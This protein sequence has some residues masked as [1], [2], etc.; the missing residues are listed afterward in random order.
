MPSH[1]AVVEAYNEATRKHQVRRHCGLVDEAVDVDADN[2]AWIAAPGTFEERIG[3][4]P[5]RLP[6]SC[7]GM[8]GTFLARAG[9]IEVEDEWNP[10]KVVEIMPQEYERLAGKG[11]SSNWKGSVKVRTRNPPASRRRTDRRRRPSTPPPPR[12]STTAA[13]SGTGSGTTTPACGPSTS[14]SSAG[15]PSTASARAATAAGPSASTP[16]PS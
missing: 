14:A 2:V 16:P 8:M 3:A 15:P 12:S 7:N 4:V 10:G 9:T 5:V 13:G 11:A 1:L 6:V